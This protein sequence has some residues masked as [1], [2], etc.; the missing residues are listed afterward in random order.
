ML[1][2]EWAINKKQDEL[3]VLEQELMVKDKL[4]VHA[5]FKQKK[6]ETEIKVAQGEKEDKAKEKSALPGLVI[7]R[8]TTNNG[9]LEFGY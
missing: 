6:N 3:K 9:H 8:F 1:D 2:Y 7:I 5:V 4:N